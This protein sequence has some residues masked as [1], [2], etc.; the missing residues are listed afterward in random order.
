M[1][2]LVIGGTGFIGS[3]LIAQLVREGHQVAVFH[4]GRTKLAEGVQ[5]IVGDRMA[6]H[7]DAL[8]ACSPEVVVDG[9]PGS[10]GETK[11]KEHSCRL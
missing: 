4:R 1:R 5:E 6:D 2:V 11:A 10:D 3:R 7:A 9:V 8:R